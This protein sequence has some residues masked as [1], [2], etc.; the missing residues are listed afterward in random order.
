VEAYQL[1]E[2]TRNTRSL[3]FC[4]LALLDALDQGE[5]L[6]TLGLGLH[7]KMTHDDPKLY[8]ISHAS[9]A[10]R[11]L[12][13]GQANVSGTST[14]CWRLSIGCTSLSHCYSS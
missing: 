3:L 2:V 6:K 11:G 10:K 13:I 14:T 7:V 12:S 5:P 9:L 4:V 1:D 8:L